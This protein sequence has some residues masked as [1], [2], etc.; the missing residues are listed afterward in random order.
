[1]SEA[2]A[3]AATGR[4]AGARTS[5]SRA[6][7]SGL[8]SSR[9]SDRTPV[10]AGREFALQVG[11]IRGSATASI[12]VANISGIDVAVDVFIGTRGGAGNGKYGHP[13]LQNRKVWRLDLQPDD[14]TANLVVTSTGDVIIQLVIDDGRLNALTVLPIG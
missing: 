14:E 10:H 3:D 9:R 6:I 4:P 8:P 12:L 13:A 5:R 7:S 2:K 1:M 11:D